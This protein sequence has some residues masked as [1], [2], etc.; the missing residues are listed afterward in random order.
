MPDV[1]VVAETLDDDVFGGEDVFGSH[2]AAGAFSVL[3]DVDGEELDFGGEKH[4]C[5]EDVVN[6]VGHGR[7]VEVEAAEELDTC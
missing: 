7:V 2:V 5:A 3:R 1:E 4:Y 6:V